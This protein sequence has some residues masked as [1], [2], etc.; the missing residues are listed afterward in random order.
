MNCPFL[1]YFGI[2]YQ[3][4]FIQYYM[5][6][7]ILYN[8]YNSIMININDLLKKV[9]IYYTFPIVVYE[10][11]MANLTSS[12]IEI[13]IANKDEIIYPIFY[14][15]M[16]FVSSCTSLFTLFSDIGMSTCRNILLIMYPLYETICS[17]D[18]VSKKN[19]WLSYWVFY[20][21]Y[22]QLNW[23]LSYFFWND[24]LELCVMYVVVRYSFLKNY[25]FHLLLYVNNNKDKTVSDVFEVQKLKI[26]S[27]WNTFISKVNT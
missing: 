17:L 18:N 22:D 15:H 4:V 21:L 5:Y 10:N 8:F 25:I 23:I 19:E 13:K 3:Y 9:H 7:P 1:E 24:V 26:K 27:N 2:I 6:I 12:E 14:N 20:I 11:N 16:I